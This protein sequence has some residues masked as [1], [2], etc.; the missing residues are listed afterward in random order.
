LANTTL[1]R[2]STALTIA[3]DIAGDVFPFL[4]AA[5]DTTPEA[6]LGDLAG[7]QPSNFNGLP[8]AD[9]Q[10]WEKERNFS[11]Q[12][13]WVL[14][15]LS[16][17]LAGFGKDYNAGLLESLL[18][19]YDCDPTYTRSTISRGRIVVKNSYLALLG[20]S[21]PAAMAE[22][23]RSERLW[24]NGF[25]PRFAILTPE[26]RPQWEDTA[27]MNRPSDIENG[28]TK[29]FNK[30]PNGN[31][32]PDPPACLTVNVSSDSFGYW[33]KYNRA[34]S[35]DL[36]TDTLPEMLWG[37]YG[38]LPTHALKVAM[39]L[40]ALDWTGNE[41]TPKIETRHMIRALTIAE[42]WRASYHRAITETSETEFNRT[43]E[44]V[45]KAISNC[46]PGGASQREICR[47][48]RD[49]RPADISLAIDEML[50]AGMIEEI[51]TDPSSKG[52]RPTVRYTLVK[53]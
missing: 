11:A 12:R 43:A 46:G 15:E 10:A 34:L 16:G 33:T 35:D 3:R 40:A 37:A 24:S 14:D 52:G 28:L 25:W 31:K 45:I 49:K 1:Y 17:L 4:L 47:A 21:T 18:R 9:Q 44:R 53:D 50:T 22:H 32:W 6:F 38:R 36:L 5:Q 2:K 26:R 23:F 7:V 39:L 8:L 41:T 48:N 30:L 51:R 29:L 42:T 27:T 20:A 19:F 13:G